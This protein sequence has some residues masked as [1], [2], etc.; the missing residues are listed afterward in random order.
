MCRACAMWAD[1][2][3]R[4]HA[5]GKLILRSP[6]KGQDGSALAGVVLEVGMVP[7]MVVVGSWREVGKR[8][9]GEGAR[10]RRGAAIVGARTDGHHT[11]G[12]GKQERAQ[13]GREERVRSCGA[14]FP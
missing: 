6:Q 2:G 12:T 7:L 14:R 8:E 4:P 5:W 10:L 11:D 13:R 9:E 3:P 1:V